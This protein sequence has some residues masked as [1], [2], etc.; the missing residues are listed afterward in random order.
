MRRIAVWIGVSSLVSLFGLGLWWHADVIAA[1]FDGDEL[2]VKKVGLVLALLAGAAGAIGA[3]TNI[4]RAVRDQV[5]RSEALAE[6][7]AGRYAPPPSLPWFTLDRG[8]LQPFAALNCWARL[9]D[10]KPV[11][12]LVGRETERNALL[13][14]AKSGP[15]VRVKIVTGDGGF[16]KSRLAAEVA[17]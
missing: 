16:G 11:A 1:A 3:I 17:D 8:E 13:D 14:W 5:A 6:K 12:A 7:A 15:G 9:Q 2:S 4:V 10:G